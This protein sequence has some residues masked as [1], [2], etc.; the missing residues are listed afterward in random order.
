M[1]QS[2]GAGCDQLPGEVLQFIEERLQLGF[3]DLDH[4]RLD[5]LG[6]L[7]EQP[8]CRTMPAG[9]TGQAVWPASIMIIEIIGAAAV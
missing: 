9:E 7:A 3:G 6:S 2:V 4:R 5:Q 1:S 8:P